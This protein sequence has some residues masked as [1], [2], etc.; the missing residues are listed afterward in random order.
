MA[1]PEF[2]LASPAVRDA[3]TEHYEFHMAMMASRMPDQ[4]PYPEE[5]AL[6]QEAV[7]RMQQNELQ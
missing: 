4:A 1:K 3:F 5:A 7:L 2:Y 6:E